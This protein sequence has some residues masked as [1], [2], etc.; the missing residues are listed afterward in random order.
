LGAC[1]PNSSN[2]AVIFCR[3]KCADEFIYFRA[4]ILSAG[5]DRVEAEFFD[6]ESRMTLD[7]KDR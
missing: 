7:R 4:K 6:Y 3:Q 5:D 1:S 2:R